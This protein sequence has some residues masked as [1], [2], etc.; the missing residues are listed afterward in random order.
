MI[1]ARIRRKRAEA[2]EQSQSA[3]RKK[4]AARAAAAELFDDAA[5][6]EP[7]EEASENPSIIGKLTGVM[8]G[9][10][11][12]L[13]GGADG[14]ATQKKSLAD[15][16]KDP[17]ARFETD[18]DEDEALDDDAS[19]AF[20]HL[21]GGRPLVIAIGVSIVLAVIA[22]LFMARDMF[23]G[24]ASP[25]P[26]AIIA[27]GGAS[28]ASETPDATAVQAPSAEVPP[29]PTVKPRDLYLDAVAALKLAAT[30]EAEA[31]ALQKLQEAA[32]LGHPPA[33]L[34]L[35]ELYKN[36]QGVAQDL[37]QARI[38]YERAASGGNIL[39]MHR[40]GVM[41]AQGEGGA[42]D[43]NAAIAWFEQAANRGLV[44]SQY[45]LGAIFHPST[46]GPASGLQD[47][48]RAYYW[49]SLASKN[50][51]DQAE[52]LA[53]GLVGSFNAEEKQ[54]QD[55]AVASWE[56]TPANTAA[57]ELSPAS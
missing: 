1:A 46:E 27:D 5:S 44:D 43:M 21:P 22:A 11:S 12:K 25:P 35:G 33:Q 24:P 16:E 10:R 20:S 42:V 13:P 48:A 40:A 54:Q 6:G 37:S 31:A 19:G 50:G 7:E 3:A 41:T 9:L 4:Q 47:A 51:D 49:Y 23:K 34:Q 39:A 45:N 14:D 55:A 56:A 29:A 17:L 57:N 30:P 15:E 18:A 36:G 28:T 32:A 8:S 38:W 26:P 2:G 53:A 52:S